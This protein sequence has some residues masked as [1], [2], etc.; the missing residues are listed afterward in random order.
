MMGNHIMGNP[1]MGNPMMR[2]P[3]Q[4]PSPEQQKN[5]QLMAIGNMKRQFQND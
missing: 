3:M 2:Q 5:M 4:M 1:M